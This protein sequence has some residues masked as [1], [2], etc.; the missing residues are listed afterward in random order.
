MKF[1]I[2]K[3]FIIFIFLIFPIFLSFAGNYNY[4][5]I[6]SLYSKKDCY[7]IIQN[8]LD[9]IGK[10]GGGIVSLDKGIFY[11]SKTLHVPSN[12]TLEGQ[13]EKATIIK[14]LSSFQ[15]VKNPVEFPNNRII[16]GL[17]GKNIV[18]K[19]L[20]VDGMN[21]SSYWNHKGAAAGIYG[22]SLE[23][24]SFSYIENVRV[25][26]VSGE[27]ILIGY[28]NKFDAVKNCY[29]ENANHGINIYMRRGP[30]LV[31][32]NIVKRCTGMGIFVES[33][34]DTIIINNIVENNQ[35][36]GIVDMGGAVFKLTEGGIISNNYVSGN[37]YS[38]IFV[39]GTYSQLKKII[40]TNNIVQNNF[41][42][43]INFYKVQE[44]IANNNIC[45]HN[46][47]LFE[48][49]NSEIS[50]NQCNN[51]KAIGNIIK[52]SGNEFAFTILQSPRIN[53][54][55][56]LSNNIIMGKS[57]KFK[58][59]W[60]P[61]KNIK[62]LS[63][64]PGIL[65]CQINKYSFKNW[66]AANI[67]S[68]ETN[69]KLENKLVKVGTH[70]LKIYFQKLKNIYGYGDI[71]YDFERPLN[72]KMANYSNINFY[73]FVSQKISGTF[74][75][76]LKDIKGDYIMWGYK[77]NFDFSKLKENQWNHFILS[78]H[79]SKITEKTKRFNWSK[80][81]SIHFVVEGKRGSF[82]FSNIYMGY[83]VT[84]N[85]YTTKQTIY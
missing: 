7:N 20:T 71:K 58:Y 80:I 69:L 75:V 77:P 84:N 83:T 46:N 66:N 11:I 79:L 39:H 51:I 34:D 40:V 25:E 33:S 49:D 4:I 1:K 29:V 21:I 52:S 61:D 70:S 56:I 27:G 16:V 44:I 67:G 3:K 68:F 50:I 30:T 18:I 12:T 81:K 14:V 73:I 45:F 13:G 23:G 78:F 64:S 5:K 17:G 43:G 54:K 47:L 55:S 32:G 72:L 63:I 35:W 22:I 15:N 60:I 42:G 59:S 57:K 10:K 41:S 9:K 2:S 8:S 28:G 19:N 24:S 31:E 65:L 36:W 85:Q 48:R 76:Y 38:G 62:A 37:Y 53:L 26:N 6:K 82:Y 74:R